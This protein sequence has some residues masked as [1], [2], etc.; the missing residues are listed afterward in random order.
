MATLI[1]RL[2]SDGQMEIRKVTSTQ[3]QIKSNSRRKFVAI[4]LDIFFLTLHCHAHLV[5][6][7]N[8]SEECLAGVTTH[9]S[10]VKMSHGSVSAHWTGDP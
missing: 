3:S 5:S 6:V 10:I 7:Y 2:A 1:N 4:C 9:S 8:S